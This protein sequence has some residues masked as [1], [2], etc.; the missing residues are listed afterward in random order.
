M[1]AGSGPHRQR[2]RVLLSLDLRGCHRALN[3]Q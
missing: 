2:L 1:N 3:L